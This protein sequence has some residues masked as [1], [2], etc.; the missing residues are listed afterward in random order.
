MAS[1][2]KRIEGS[3]TLLTI[4]SSAQSVTAKWVI[5]VLP[6]PN[7][8]MCCVVHYAL[9][10]VIPLLRGDFLLAEEAIYTQPRAH[11]LADSPSSAT[12]RMSLRSVP[13]MGS[14][15]SVSLPPSHPPFPIYPSH[16]L[17]TSGYFLPLV[18]H[19][20][21]TRRPTSLLFQAVSQLQLQEGR[22]LQ[23]WQ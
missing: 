9:G 8:H 16:F 18:C 13:L 22:H 21:T 1:D 12:M 3:G 23:H 15:S 19:L 5:R 10:C 6:I 2:L 7:S 20:L 4:D 11:S 14:P 17:I